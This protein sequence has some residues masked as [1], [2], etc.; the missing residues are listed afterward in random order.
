MGN[1]QRV[2][3]SRQQFDIQDNEIVSKIDPR[4]ADSFI[5]ALDRVRFV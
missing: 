2:D 3:I 5:R 4:T 1:F